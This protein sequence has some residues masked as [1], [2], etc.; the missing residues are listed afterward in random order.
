ME[1]F[2]LTVFTPLPK[3]KHETDPA[4]PR[5]SDG[6]GVA[7][8]RVRMVS[9]EGKK[10]YRERAKGECVNAQF[11]NW[12][13]YRLLVRG[14]EKVRTVLLWFAVAS[15]PGLASQGRCRSGSAR[16]GVTGRTA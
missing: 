14:K 7:A 8:W 10:I 13:G 15:R 4:K 3:N 5:K 12:G 16:R 6:P 2:Y 9:E 1:Q 11:R